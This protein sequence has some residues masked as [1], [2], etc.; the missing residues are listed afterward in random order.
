M[1]TRL[2]GIAGVIQ[3]VE[4]GNTPDGLP[5]IITRPF[6]SLLAIK[7]SAELVVSVAQ[8]AAFIIQQ[9]ASLLPPVF[10]RD[11]SI[12]NLIHCGDA[13]TTFLVDFGTAVLA[14]RGR[15]LTDGVTGTS[16]FI[17][18]SVLE[19]EGYTL[20]SELESLMYIVIFLA[21]DGVAHWGNKPVGPWAL[22]FKVQCF[23]EQASFER[24]IVQRCRTDLLEVVKRLRNLFW[25]PTYQSNITALQFQQAL[26]PACSA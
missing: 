12:G 9:L 2:A 5:Y 19:G 18:R 21:V 1:L 8:R 4:Q 3:L 11:I 16:T 13:Q 7:D 15:H 14:P 23:A 22:A 26:Q 17:A 6:G 25:Q 20:S 24:Y 10:H